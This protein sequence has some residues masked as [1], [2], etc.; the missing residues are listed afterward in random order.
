MTS[1]RHG[2]A[3]NFLR[4]LAQTLKCPRAGSPTKYKSHYDRGGYFGK[5]VPNDGRAG[6]RLV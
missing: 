3:A 6:S 1:R 2:T 4:K 5:V